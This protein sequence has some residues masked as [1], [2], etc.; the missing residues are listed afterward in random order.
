MYSTLGSYERLAHLQYIPLLGSEKALY[1]LRRLKFAYDQLNGIESGLFDDD[2]ANVLRKMMGK[3]VKT[4]SLGRLLDTLAFSLNVC[5]ERTY[6][7][8]PAMK[9][10]PL[11]SRGRMIDGFEAELKGKEILTAP[12][13]ALLEKKG[14]KED[15]AYSVVRAVIDRMVGIACDTAVSKGLNAIGVSGGVS[16]NGPICEM[17]DDEAEKRGMSVLHHSRVPNGDGG[18]SV[19]QAA[20]ALRRLQ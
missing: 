3:S 9:L 10:E 4:S 2:S 13:I 6:D 7:G 12:L 17:I 1:D 15:I 11:L 18:I 20:I 8:E 5:K 14:R 16:Y 19:G